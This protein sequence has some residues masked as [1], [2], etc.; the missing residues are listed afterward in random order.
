MAKKERRWISLFSV[1]FS[2]YIYFFRPHHDHHHHFSG[3]TW[4][5]FHLHPCCSFNYILS[6][7]R[8]ILFYNKKKDP[9]TST[10]PLLLLIDLLSLLSCLAK[11][12]WDLRHDSWGRRDFRTRRWEGKN[13]ERE[14]PETMN[15]IFNLLQSQRRD[16]SHLLLSHFLPSHLQSLTPL[17]L[18]LF[19][20]SLPRLQ[21]S[22]FPS[23]LASS[24]RL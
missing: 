18:W 1:P 15:A 12:T 8:H 5:D 21:Y 19:N 6:C 4:R 3:E 2:S 22:F 17:L 10:E 16:S 20:F 13:K 11:E 9:L 14:R 23:T 7:G 24:F